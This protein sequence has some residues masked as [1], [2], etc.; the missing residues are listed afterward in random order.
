MLTAALHDPAI[1]AYRDNILFK[2]TVKRYASAWHHREPF[3]YFIVSVIPAL[4][5]PLTALIPWLIKPWRECAKAKDLRILLPLIWVGLVVLFFSSS[6]G[7]RGVYV[8]PAVPA[9]VLCVA[10]FLRQLAQRSGPRRLLFGIAAALAFVTLVGGVVLSMK[11]ATRAALLNEYDIDV[12][13]PLLAMGVLMTLCCLLTRIRYGFA[14]FFMC[15]G[16][17]L[18]VVNF[19]INP[20]M[21]DARSGRAFVHQIEA[22]TAGFSE[23][24]IAAYKEQYLL[25]LTRPLVNFGHARWQEADKEADDAAAWLNAGQGRAL[26]VDSATRKRCFGNAHAEE[27]D[28]ANSLEWFVVTGNADPQCAAR[29]SLRAALS[30]APPTR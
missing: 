4:W 19:M 20:V 14:A 10:P 27:L 7:K 24:G 23:V 3:W 22:R 1:A 15:I 13:P 5:L 16:A 21:N 29:G 25:Y 26:I 11:A 2:Q 6:A 9:L 30:Y 18:L 8:L 17:A 12:V 28:E